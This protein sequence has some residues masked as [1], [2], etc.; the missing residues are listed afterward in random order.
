MNFVPIARLK[1][2]LAPLRGERTD[3]ESTL[4]PMPL[5][6]AAVGDGSYE[7]LDGFKRLTL[8]R[9]FYRERVNPP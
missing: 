9:A 1:M 2:T 5:R 3:R 7:V 6:V 8:W 4:A